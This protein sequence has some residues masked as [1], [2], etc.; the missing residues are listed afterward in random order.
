MVASNPNASPEV[1]PMG[2]YGRLEE[3]ASVAVLLA[4]NEY[5]TGQTISVNGG[6]YMT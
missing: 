6:W 3:V 1:I 4:E 5:M 2:R